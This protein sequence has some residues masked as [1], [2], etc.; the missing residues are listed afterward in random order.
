MGIHIKET[1]EEVGIQYNIS[2][3]EKTYKIIRFNKKD[4]TSVKNIEKQRQKGKE[5]IILSSTIIPKAI[6]KK[7][8]KDM[9][10]HLKDINDLRELLWKERI[11]HS[12]IING[13]IYSFLKDKLKNQKINKLHCQKA[14]SIC[15]LR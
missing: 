5:I 8:E 10:I 14:A 3:Q 2:C 9:E 15:V 7:Y 13:V 6:K 11:N 4:K 1:K 12:E